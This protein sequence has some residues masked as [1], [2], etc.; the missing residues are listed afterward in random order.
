MLK[1]AKTAVI[2]TLCVLPF[3]TAA[4]AQNAKPGETPKPDT[5]AAPASDAITLELMDGSTITGTMSLKELAVETEFGPLKVPITRIVSFT[6]GIDNHADF[7]KKI[8]DLVE[9]L[10]SAETGVRDAAQRELA[11]IAPQIRVELAKYQADADP[12]RKLRIGAILD[13]LA[14]ASSDEDA[15]PAPASM[16][17]LDSIETPDFSIVGRIVPKTF[18]VASPY[19]VLNIKLADIRRAKRMGPAKAQEIQKTVSVDGTNMPTMKW[20]ES[21]VR[22]EKGDKVSVKADGTLTLTPWGSEATSTPDGAGNYGWYMQGQIPMGALIGR[23]GK[24]GKVFKVGANANFTAE[25]SGELQLA[26]GIIQNYANNPFPGKYSVKIK[27]RPKATG[28]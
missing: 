19:G 14:E 22:V 13:E 7:Q 18:E 27:V 9:K 11:G 21:G 20:R 24:N 28:N 23:I 2:V 26:V 6:P 4:M 17:R 10:G 8:A 15:G 5:A 3:A 1:F 16:I 12:E 25:Q